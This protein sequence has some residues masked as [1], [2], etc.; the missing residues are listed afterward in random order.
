[1]SRGEPR[2]YPLDLVSVQ[3]AT[4][5][6]KRQIAE[7]ARIVS[8]Y[9]LDPRRADRR[10]EHECVV[11]FYGSGMAGQACTPWACASCGKEATHGNTATPRLCNECAEKLRLCKSC[12]ADIGLMR[13]VKL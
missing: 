7:L 11:C 1:M 4:E 12:G 9:Q 13:R 6:N 3:T 8:D 2:R 5:R 10:K